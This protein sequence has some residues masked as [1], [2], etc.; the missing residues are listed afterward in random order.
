MEVRV[1]HRDEHCFGRRF[2]DPRDD[3]T[4]HACVRLEELQA[5]ARIVPVG[6]PCVEHSARIEA[7]ACAD[8]R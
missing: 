7:I 5:P 2:D 8:G 1:R 6:G 3:V 4:V